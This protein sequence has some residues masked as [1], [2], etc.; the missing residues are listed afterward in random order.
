[1]RRSFTPLSNV[2][3]ARGAAVTALQRWNIAR[4]ARGARNHTKNVSPPCK[5]RRYSHRLSRLRRNREHSTW[6]WTNRFSLDSLDTNS[7]RR[8]QRA[9]KIPERKA[10]QCKLRSRVYMYAQVTRGAAFNCRTMPLFVFGARSRFT[11]GWVIGDNVR[12]AANNI[13]VR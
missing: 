3:R 2:Y 5:K 1:M 13:R 7:Q 6:Q 12:A 8:V 11:Y 9:A 10:T 4:G